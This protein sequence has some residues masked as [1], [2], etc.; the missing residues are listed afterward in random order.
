MN[1]FGFSKMIPSNPYLGLPWMFDRSKSNGLKYIAEK[2]QSQV[3][4]WNN[5]FLSYASNEVLI[6]SVA[7]SIH[8]YSMFCFRFPQGLIQ[9]INRLLAKFWWGGKDN[10]RKIHWKC[11]MMLVRS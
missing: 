10:H 8:V 6:K 1:V 11:G 3:Q 5:Q 9:D 4:H 7:Q 2:V